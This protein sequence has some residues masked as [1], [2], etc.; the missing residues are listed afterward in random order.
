MG[1]R[2]V[3]QHISLKGKDSNRFN[4]RVMFIK[5]TELLKVTVSARSPGAVG[6]SFKA[7]VL[8]VGPLDVLSF[9][10]LDQRSARPNSL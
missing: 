1:R 5:T 10:E 9:G 8:T 7:A 3:S 6:P 4:P 2:K